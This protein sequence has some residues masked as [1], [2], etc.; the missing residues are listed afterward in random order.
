MYVGPPD[1]IATDADVYEV[2]VKAHQSIGKVERYYAAIRRAFEVIS[3]D[4][5]TSTTTKD[6]I[7]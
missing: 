2:L 5:G 4:I 3:A 7:L 1:T 6:N